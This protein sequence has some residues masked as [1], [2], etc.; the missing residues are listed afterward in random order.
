MFY[1]QMEL[2]NASENAT[3]ATGRAATAATSRTKK[4]TTS[5][6]GEETKEGQSTGYS[7]EES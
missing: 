3:D 2:V 6:K 4:G 5:R 7:V 1:Q